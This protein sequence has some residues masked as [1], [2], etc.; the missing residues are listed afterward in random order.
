MVSFAILIN[1]LLHFEMIYNV[2]PCCFHTAVSHCANTS[3]S[4]ACDLHVLCCACLDPNR[5]P[6]DRSPDRLIWSSLSIA[7]LALRLSSLLVVVAVFVQIVRSQ[8]IKCHQV[9]NFVSLPMATTTTASCKS[10]LACSLRSLMGKRSLLRVGE[11]E[12]GKVSG[13][14]GEWE[15]GACAASS[16]SCLL[17]IWLRLVLLPRQCQV[18]V[19]A[20]KAL[21][22]QTHTDTHTL[23]NMY[24][25]EE[26]RQTHSYTHA[27]PIN[28]D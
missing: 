23:T 12:R 7:V 14:W 2:A 21:H 10:L 11:E 4:L 19:S 15:C 24:T 1:I 3:C 18:V 6:T 13:R 26:E 8:E 25:D 16:R 5:D 22:T 28:K 17:M 9:V 20:Q 27:R